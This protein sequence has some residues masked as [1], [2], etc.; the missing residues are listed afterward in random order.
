MDIWIL[1]TDA[2]EKVNNWLKFLSD[3]KQDVLCCYTCTDCADPLSIDPYDQVIDN[4]FQL[5]GE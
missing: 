4:E 2:D 1:N 5:P 3:S